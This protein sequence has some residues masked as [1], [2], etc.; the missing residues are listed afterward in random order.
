MGKAI[1]MQVTLN[2]P[3]DVARRAQDAGL[4]TV[5]AVQGLL[6]EAMRRA[7]GRKLLSMA[8]RLH[9]AG[10]PPM[11]EDA[12]DDLIHEVRAERKAPNAGR[13]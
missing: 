10:I 13:S 3:D 7:A 6:E 5:D 9:A 11:S 8:E 1:A 12:L 2:L 4:L